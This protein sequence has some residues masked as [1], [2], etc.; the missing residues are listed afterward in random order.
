M[1]KGFTQQYCIDYSEPYAPVVKLGSLRS[2][3]AIAASNN[4]EIHQGDITTAYLQGQLDEEI[5][6]EVP[7]GVMA[8]D[9]KPGIGKLACRLLSGLYGLKQSGR[10]WNKAWDENL[11]GKCHFHRSAV[12]HAVY[13][14]IGH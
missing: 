3:L 14:R 7:E 5:Y 6:M 9:L 2:L 10:I 4:Y 8:S 1:T 12:D 11:V 13:Y